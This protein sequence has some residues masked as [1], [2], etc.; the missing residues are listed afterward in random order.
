MIGVGLQRKCNLAV[1][2]LVKML[3]PNFKASET[4]HVFFLTLLCFLLLM[5]FLSK[6]QAQNLLYKYTCTH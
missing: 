2:K 1:R 3:K 4:R 5:L 6:Y